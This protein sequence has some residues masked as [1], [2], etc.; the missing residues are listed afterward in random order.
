MSFWSF[1][2]FGAWWVFRFFL[3]K[4]AVGKLVDW[5]ISSA[6][7]LFR[8]TSTLDYLKICKFIT[9]RSLEA[10]NI[11]KSLIITAMINWNCLVRVFSR[12]F[13]VFLFF[14]QIVTCQPDASSVFH[15]CGTTRSQ[16]T[17]QQSMDRPDTTVDNI[18]HSSP[19]LCWKK[20]KTL[21]SHSVIHTN[22]A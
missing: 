5:F 8:L 12:F 3:F 11:K 6:K 15:W 10:V 16:A 13:K 17:L 21:M 9:Y 1:I 4:R 19:V 22:E 14:F 20:N 7:C 2:A 18:Y